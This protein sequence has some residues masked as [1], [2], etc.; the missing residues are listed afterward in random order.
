MN[1]TD[2]SGPWQI[3][4]RSDMDQSHLP[5]V[6]ENPPNLAQGYLRWLGYRLDRSISPNFDS[7]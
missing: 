3:P 7:S 2:A 4:S 6:M 5:G 1:A